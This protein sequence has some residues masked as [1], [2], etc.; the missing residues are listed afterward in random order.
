MADAP[1]RGTFIV[2]YANIADTWT[3]AYDH[4][5]VKE[6][7]EAAWEHVSRAMR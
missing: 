5:I 1:R 7:E 6:E 3:E 2:D 4:V